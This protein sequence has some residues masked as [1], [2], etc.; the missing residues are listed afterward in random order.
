MQAQG[1]PVRPR[2][3]R[4]HGLGRIQS[5]AA[6]ARRRPAKGGGVIR[7]EEKGGPRPRAQALLG[8]GTVTFAVRV[9]V[10]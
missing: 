3:G 7:R 10:S 5:C 1:V 4:E 6:A 8:C 2:G 9:Q